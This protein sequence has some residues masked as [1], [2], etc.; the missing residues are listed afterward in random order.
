[1]SLFFLFETAAGYA[2]FEKLEFDEVSMTLPQMQK[3]I[4]TM[5]SFSRIV[6]L[7]AFSPF[8]TAEMSLENVTALAEGNVSEDLRTFL[9]D[10]LPKGTKKNPVGL[11]V[12]DSRLAKSI[13][14]GLQIQCRISDVITEVF[15]G[16][17]THFVKFLKNSEFGQSDL[18]KAQLGL[19]HAF[20]RRRVAMDVNRQDKHIIQSSALL[21][22]MDKNINTFC[23]RIKEWYGWHF[24]E[25]A[26]LIPDNTIY[27]KVANLIGDKANA[28]D[29]LVP[30][31][32]EI[33]GDG[34]LAQRVVDSAKT[35]MGQEIG[36]TDLT[37]VNELSGRILSQIEFRTELQDYL[38][39]RMNNVAPNLTALIG[40]GVGAKL[41]S[42][43]GSLVNLAK[44]PASTVQILGAEKALFRA[45]KTKS[46]TPK[47][48]LL[49]NSTFI[50]RAGAKDKGKI[51][52]FVANKCVLAA[53]ID[54]FVVSQ[55][56]RFGEEMRRQVE[57]RLEFLASGKRSR[58][59]IEVMDEVMAELKAENL[60]TEAAD[61]EKKKKKKKK[62]K[63]EVAPEEVEAQVEEEAPRKKKKKKTEE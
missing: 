18:E 43:A 62:K 29:E 24:P 5:E 23:M 35:S 36:E 15:R 60:Y 63:A 33:I 40:E 38:L 4:S 31:L 12:S 19:G 11:A 30:Q 46:N 58:R 10:S 56:T 57:D 16:I 45:L 42:K 3:A 25:L 21:E 59:N 14:E 28:T 8:T 34:D 6:H 49:Y 17:R 48:G 7:K 54:Y 53:R 1:M 44:Y 20:S 22:L 61:G 39:D 41:I 52:R 27:V 51:S 9:Q 55:T 47:Y 32:E 50:G 2:L 26:R 37:A 13:S